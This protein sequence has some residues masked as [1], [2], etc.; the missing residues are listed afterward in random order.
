MNQSPHVCLGCGWQ[1]LHVGYAKTLKNF[2]NLSKPG[3]IWHNTSLMTIPM[4][5]FSLP[6]FHR[7][8]MGIPLFFVYQFLPSSILCNL[9]SFFFL[10][11]VCGLIIPIKKLKGETSLHRA[12]E[13]ALRLWDSIVAPFP[14]HIGFK[15]TKGECSATWPQKCSPQN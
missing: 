1:V 2:N 4:W 3:I 10:N 6:N 5:I 13:A 11:H 15:I 8:I 9:P 12:L 7:T 14:L